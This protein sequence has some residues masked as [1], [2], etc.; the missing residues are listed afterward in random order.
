M[1]GHRYKRQYNIVQSA[2]SDMQ[3]IRVHGKDLELI[4]DVQRHVEISVQGHTLT[5]T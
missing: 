5:R 1:W 3:C 4:R 2:E